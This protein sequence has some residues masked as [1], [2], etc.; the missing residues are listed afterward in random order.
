MY[1][2]TVLKAYKRAARTATPRHST[3][4]GQLAAAREHTSCPLRAHAAHASS[5][6]RF[7]GTAFVPRITPVAV[8]STRGAL[9][10]TRL[11]SASAENP[12]KTTECTAPM[13]AHA[14]IV[15]GSRST[16]GR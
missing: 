6:I 4:I 11:A 15:M 3:C 12:P 2:I 7:S 5:A 14:S 9:S 16:M 1:L 8:T 10:I 13:R